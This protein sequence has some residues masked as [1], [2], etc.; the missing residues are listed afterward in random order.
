GKVIPPLPDHMLIY[1]SVGPVVD[2]LISRSRVHCSYTLFYDA[3]QSVITKIY[4][5]LEYKTIA[6]IAANGNS[7][8]KTKEVATL[9]AY[10]NTNKAI[11]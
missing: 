6:C 8:I 10:T 4:P 3:V 2:Q 9:L 5:D 1:A 7:W 11:F